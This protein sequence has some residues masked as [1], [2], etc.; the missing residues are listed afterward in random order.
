MRGFGFAGTDLTA[1]TVVYLS[2]ILLR[3]FLSGNTLPGTGGFFRRLGLILFTEVGNNGLYDIKKFSFS[4]T[5][6]FG[7]TPN[8]AYSH[9]QITLKC[10]FLKSHF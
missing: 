10:L 6:G 2:V 7:T 1:V 8:L 3:V 5:V 4:S 9:S